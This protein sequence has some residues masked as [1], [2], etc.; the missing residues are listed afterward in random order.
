MFSSSRKK[1]LRHKFKKAV[2]PSMSA[3][4][5][6]RYWRHR[7][8]RLKD[9]DFAIAAGIAFGAA[10]SFTPLPGS[11]VL[12][13]V[14]LCLI[15]R[16]NVISGILGTFLGNPWTLPFMWWGSY[17]T[18][19]WTFIQLGFNVR[20]MPGDF[21]WDH[22]VTEITHDPMRLIAPWVVGGFLLMILSW[23]FFYFISRG[24]LVHLRSTHHL[25]KENRLHREA[26]SITGQKE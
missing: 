26:R 24:V 17:M 11:H 5:T 9:G 6:M 2:W 23:P 14:A 13:A 15:F 4:R 18:G 3:K 12:G 21:S 20:N 16:C 25:W 8:V 19:K 7:V 1:K 10:I 22:L